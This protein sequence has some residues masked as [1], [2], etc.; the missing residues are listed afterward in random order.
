ML[1]MPRM[2]SA[3]DFADRK[4]LYRWMTRLTAVAAPTH[5][6]RSSAST[7]SPS[8]MR[9]VCVLSDPTSTM[10]VSCLIG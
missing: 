4:G 2:R 9:A 5:K 8:R 7:S 1:I 10:L 6:V 3:I